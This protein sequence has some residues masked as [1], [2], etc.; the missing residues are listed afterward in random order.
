MIKNHAKITDIALLMLAVIGEQ[1]AFKPYEKTTFNIHSGS[2]LNRMLYTQ[3][4]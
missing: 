3:S 2:Y 1:T 4:K